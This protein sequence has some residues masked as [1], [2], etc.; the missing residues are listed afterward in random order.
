MAHNIEMLQEDVVEWLNKVHPDRTEMAVWAKM[1]EETGEIM[2]DPHDI[3]EWA[4]VMIVFLDLA[5]R[6]GH[7]MDDILMTARDKLIVNRARKWEINRH[8][9]MSH[10]PEW[11][12]GE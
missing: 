12:A 8:G 10:V 5:N 9:V 7:Y 1:L 4:D 3:G 6:Y 11:P 2:V